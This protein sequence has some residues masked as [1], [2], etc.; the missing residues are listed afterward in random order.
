MDTKQ[1]LAEEQD[2]FFEMFDSWVAEPL[3]LPQEYCLDK[4]VDSFIIDKIKE[5]LKNIPL[6]HT[7]IIKYKNFEQLKLYITQQFRRKYAQSKQK[8]KKD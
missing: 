4:E 3:A 5:A 6:A 2:T 1:Q 8:N 7:N